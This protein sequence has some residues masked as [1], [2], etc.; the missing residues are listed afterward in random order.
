MIPCVSSI[1]FHAAR[2]NEF[3]VS[4]RITRFEVEGRSLRNKPHPVGNHNLSRR[5]TNKSSGSQG[6]PSLAPMR[7]IFPDT[8][9]I[10]AKPPGFIA[11]HIE[12]SEL[13]ASQRTL[14]APRPSPLD[15]L[16][17]RPEP[18]RRTSPKLVPTHKAPFRSRRMF[19]TMSE[20]K[21]WEVFQDSQTPRPIHRATPPPIKPIHTDP[22]RSSSTAPVFS[23]RTPR[24][25]FITLHPARVRIASP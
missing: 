25:R 15:H 3:G 19:H 17:I 5:S 18:S 13:S 14:S 4:T 12:P 10:L 11:A 8:L 7:R 20:G 2:P 22:S 16:R 9:S 6:R 1:I 24:C 23:E 21:P